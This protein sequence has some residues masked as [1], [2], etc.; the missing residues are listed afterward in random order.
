VLEAELAS[1][2]AKA[3]PLR[4]A[5]QER[6]RDAYTALKTQRDEA[7]EHEVEIQVQRL[8]ETL[9]PESWMRWARTA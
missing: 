4:R 9:D 5:A 8:T 1:H 7:R 6:L 2:N 3:L